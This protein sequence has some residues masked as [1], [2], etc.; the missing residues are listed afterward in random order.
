MTEEGVPVRT[1]SPVCIWS[2]FWQ[3]E[4]DEPVGRES[5]ERSNHLRYL[6]CKRETEPGEDSRRKPTRRHRRGVE[7]MTGQHNALKGKGLPSVHPSERTAPSRRPKN[8]RSEDRPARNTEM[9]EGRL[10]TIMGNTELR[11][12][13]RLSWTI[14]VQG[15]R[16]FVV[17]R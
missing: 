17:F 14:T 10:G 12:S 15:R 9:S 6:K 5:P 8:Q 4:R 3:L 16:Q 11:A 13:I 7:E 2:S 1:T